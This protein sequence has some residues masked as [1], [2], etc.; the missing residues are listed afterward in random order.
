MKIK[1]FEHF[2]NFDMTQFVIA[3]DVTEI[4]DCAFM[5]CTSL[6]EI[7]FPDSVK[8]I[9]R[10]CFCGCDSLENVSFSALCKLEKIDSDAFGKC[11]NLKEVTLPYQVDVIEK[12]AFGQ[13]YELEKITMPEII[14]EIKED[15]FLGCSPKSI[16][17]K[18]K[19]FNQISKFLEYFEEEKVQTI[20]NIDVEI[21]R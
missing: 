4:E 12:E 9:G 6:K 13:C 8:H 1:E 20:E 5:D 16:I 11:F 14:G 21:F 7:S 2:R 18:N 15:A 3:Q 17:Y 10:A 19:E